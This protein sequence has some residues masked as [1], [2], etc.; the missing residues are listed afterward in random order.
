MNR[1]PS[2]PRESS[3]AG[4]K[5]EQEDKGLLRVNTPNA[6]HKRIYGRVGGQRCTVQKAAHRV[7]ARLGSYRL[8]TTLGWMELVLIETATSSP[9]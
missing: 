5:W 4:R 6:D 2:V 1:T 7:G 3:R 9:S 8:E